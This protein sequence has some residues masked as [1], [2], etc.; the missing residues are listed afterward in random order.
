[1]IGREDAR[2]DWTRS[3][4]EIDCLIRAY[5]PWP[6]AYTMLDG[7]TLKVLR[8][9]PLPDARTRGAPGTVVAMERDVGVSTRE[10]VLVLDVVQLTGRRAVDAAAFARG[11]RGFVGSV[12]GASGEGAS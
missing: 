10:G 6:G 2:I 11:Q 8:A 12:L 9:H 1:M 4:R 3:A 5:T 7:Q